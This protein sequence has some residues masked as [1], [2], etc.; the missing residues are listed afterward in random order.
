MRSYKSWQLIFNIISKCKIMHIGRNNLRHAHYVDTNKSN[1]LSLTKSERDVSLVFDS[2]LNFNFTPTV[3]LTRL[4]KG[5]GLYLE[6]LLML[7][8]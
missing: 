2:N 7:L 5:L 6:V 8:I 3:S 1:M 4:T